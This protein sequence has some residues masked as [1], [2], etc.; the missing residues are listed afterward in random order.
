MNGE[1]GNCPYYDDLIPRPIGLK[2]L[3][4]ILGYWSRRELAPPG[5][6]RGPGMAFQPVWGPF[7]FRAHR[8]PRSPL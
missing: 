3:V 8:G 6:G 5:P 4:K 7:P 1:L 2:R